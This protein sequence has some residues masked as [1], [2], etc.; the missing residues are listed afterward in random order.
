MD[1]HGPLVKKSSVHN[2]LKEP[3]LLYCCLHGGKNRSKA[4]RLQEEIYV[5]IK[6][7]IHIHV[8]LAR[9]CHRGLRFY[10]LVTEKR[11]KSV[12]S[13][14]YVTSELGVLKYW[15][16]IP[17][18]VKGA[19]LVPAVDVL[20]EVCSSNLAFSFLN[21]FWLVLGLY[22]VVGGGWYL[23]ITRTRLSFWH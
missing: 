7:A 17:C 13:T 3:A 8:R 9:M 2:S 16:L 6:K 4:A 18:T 10:V 21:F 19:C 14:M 22:V 1:G 11:E 20:V 23:E 15:L 5:C 12:H